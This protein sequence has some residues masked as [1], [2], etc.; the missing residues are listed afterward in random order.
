MKEGFEIVNINTGQTLATFDRPDSIYF[1]FNKRFS[2]I[3]Y[4]ADFDAVPTF[5]FFFN[6]C[7]GKRDSMLPARM[8]ENTFLYEISCEY[9]DG[10]TVERSFSIEHA[11]MRNELPLVKGETCREEMFKFAYF[12]RSLCL[13]SINKEDFKLEVSKC[14][15][16]SEG[17]LASEFGLLDFYM[18]RLLVHDK[19][20]NELLTFERGIFDFMVSSP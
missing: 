17:R 18:D 8:F 14:E 20:E 9:F 19:G 5:L 13:C 6:A 7:K 16:F 12:D 2:E 4:S 11:A 10:F 3:I 1:G 15:V